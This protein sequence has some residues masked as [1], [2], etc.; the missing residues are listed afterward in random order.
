MVDGDAQPN[1]FPYEKL[2]VVVAGSGRGSGAC[3]K[4]VYL[5]VK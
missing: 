4:R 1:A 3:L 5:K 2:V